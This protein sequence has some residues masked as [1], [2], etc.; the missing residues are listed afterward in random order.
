VT[1]SIEIV[2]SMY[3]LVDFSRFGALLVNRRSAKAAVL[4]FF[5]RVSFVLSVRSCVVKTTRDWFAAV[6]SKAEAPG[7]GTSPNVMFAGGSISVT[8]WVT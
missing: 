3:R 8:A 1:N 2:S 4:I 6:Q 7:V 5:R